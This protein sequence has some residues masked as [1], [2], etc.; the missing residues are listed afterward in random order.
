MKP[1]HQSDNQK[2]MSGRQ[3]CEYLCIGENNDT[4]EKVFLYR[5]FAPGRCD[6][7]G[8]G[9][10]SAEPGRSQRVTYWSESDIPLPRSFSA[11]LKDLEKPAV[12]EMFERFARSSKYH[13]AMLRF[14]E[15]LAPKSSA[16]K[17]FRRASNKRMKEWRAKRDSERAAGARS[18]NATTAEEKYND[19][20]IDGANKNQTP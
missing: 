12:V 19:P 14:L 11:L 4:A 13:V 3:S 7:Y 10:S 6:V 2:V 15:L 1:H 16:V 5:Y 8:F 9:L 20:I 17:A 18:I